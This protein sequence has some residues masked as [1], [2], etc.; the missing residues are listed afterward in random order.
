MDGINNERKS[1]TFKYVFGTDCNMLAAFELKHGDHADVDDNLCYITVGTGVGIGLII[2]GSE[3]TGM[4]HP[5]GGHTSMQRSQIDKDHYPNFPGSCVFHGNQCVDGLCTNTAIIMRLG[6]SSVQE[7]E[8]LSD[9]HLIW[10]IVGEYIGTLCA[11]LYLTLSLQKFVIGGG[12]MN[13]GETLFAKIRKHFKA[14]I[15]GYL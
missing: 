6:L 5:E 10:E 4:I 13:R 15:G 12:I 2:N 8:D 11:N 3:V 1:K 7:V 14:K 9:D